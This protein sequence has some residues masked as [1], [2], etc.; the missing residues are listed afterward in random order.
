MIQYVKISANERTAPNLSA[1]V[2]KTLTRGTKLD[3][4]YLG[5][6][7]AQIYNGYVMAPT[8]V[9]TTALQDTDPNEQTGNFN[10]F[11]ITDPVNTEPPAYVRP[12]TVPAT[13]PA[14]TPKP[15]TVPAKPTPVAPLP[16]API[17]PEPKKIQ[18]GYGWEPRQL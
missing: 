17:V 12:F 8:F 18:F 1:P 10:W 5:N 6:G 14:T 2:V 7:W 16:V 3:V 11:G 13:V 15:A 9:V 4:K